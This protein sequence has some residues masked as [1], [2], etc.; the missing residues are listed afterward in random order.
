V[1]LGVPPHKI[2]TLIFGDRRRD[3][4]DDEEEEED[5][6]G[7]RFDFFVSFCCSFGAV[8]KEARMNSLIQLRPK[9][10]LLDR[11]QV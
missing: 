3:D 6:D 9:K 5:H 1:S 4:G 2:R 11:V 8:G 10:Y 7:R